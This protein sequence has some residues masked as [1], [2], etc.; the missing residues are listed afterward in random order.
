M[1]PACEAGICY[2]SLGVV[3][4]FAAGL[5]SHP[6]SSAEVY[7]LMDQMGSTL[8]ALLAGVVAKLDLVTPCPCGQRRAS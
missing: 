1:A 6:L 2:A 8:A 7:A 3:T 4:N 5:S